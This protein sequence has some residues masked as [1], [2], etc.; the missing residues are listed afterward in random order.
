MSNNKLTVLF[1]PLDG[2][3][4][5][6]ACHGLA[7]ELHRRGHRVIF[8]IDVAFKGKLTRYG[9][10]EVLHSLPPDP[11]ADP[12]IDFWADFIVKHKD[13]LKRSPIEIVESMTAIALNT[14]FDGVK[15]RDDHYK[16]IV[17]RVKPDVIVIDSYVGCPALTE[18]A[19]PWILLYSGAPLLAFNMDSL[20]P[21]WSG[22]CLSFTSYLNNYY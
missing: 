15:A 9:F 5:I 6:N 19:I 20:T 14:M 18:S 3:G 8:A 2:W 1:A 11:N 7:E 4:H 12:N 17:H 10:E 13:D 21:G 22:R 16:E